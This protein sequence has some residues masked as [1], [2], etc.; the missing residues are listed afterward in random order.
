M[1]WRRI[2][3]AGSALATWRNWQTLNTFAS[4]GGLFP[5]RGRS[6]PARRNGRTQTL[7]GQLRVLLLEHRKLPCLY[8]D[9]HSSPSSYPQSHVCLRSHYFWEFALLRS[10]RFTHFYA[11][12]LLIRFR[13]VYASCVSLN[14][15]GTLN[16]CLASFWHLRRRMK[17]SAIRFHF[18]FGSPIWHLARR[19][20][21]TL[22]KINYSFHCQWRSPQGC[23]E[24]LF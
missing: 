19:A 7:A 15:A 6:K 9:A 21:K 17:F 11:P 13:F 2:S 16:F 23:A 22:G 24:R 14:S 10:P 3:T 12:C 8:C 5:Y 1:R 4:A 18:D 20:Q